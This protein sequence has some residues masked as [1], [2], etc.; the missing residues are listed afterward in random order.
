MRA[1]ILIF[2]PI[3]SVTRSA[4]ATLSLGY[5][6]TRHVRPAV[7]FAVSSIIVVPQM[8]CQL[9]SLLEYLLVVDSLHMCGKPEINDSKAAGTKV[10]RIVEMNAIVLPMTR[11]LSLMINHVNA[12]DAM[13][14][15]ECSTL[16]DDT[17]VAIKRHVYS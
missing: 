13:L 11:C 15:A 16:I 17:K 4:I 9:R 3:M 7:G 5:R 8:G 6:L 12:H 2:S 14:N 1:G 10:F